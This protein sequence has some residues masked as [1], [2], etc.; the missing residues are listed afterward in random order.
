MAKTSHLIAF[1]LFFLLANPVLSQTNDQT[2]KKIDSLFARY[3]SQTP[4]VAVAIIKNG[5]VIFKKGYGMANLEND[6]PITPQ[7]VFHIASV[8]KQFTAFSIY[9]LA[10]QGK[11]SLEDD[12]R[13]YIPELPNYGTTIKIRHLLAHTS[14]LRDQWAILTL[15]GWRMDDVITTEQILKLVTNQ[16]STN[17]KPGSAFS[18]S[19][20]GYTLL[21][22]IVHRITGKTFSAYTSEQIFKPLGMTNT[23]F[24]DDH[25]RII[26]NRADSY[27][28]ISNTYYNKR[29]NFATVGATGLQTTVEDLSKWALN[30]EKPVVGDSKLI[31]A[32]N[33]PSYLDNG[34]KIVFTIIDG[35]TL[36]HAKAQ[37]LRNY[38]G[39]NIIKHGGHDAGFRAFLGRFPDQ[40]FSIITLSNDEHYEAFKTG[41]E[42]AEF[43]LKNDLHEKK[44]NNVIPENTSANPTVNYSPNLKEFEG[45]YHNDEL[46]TNY[47]FKTLGNKLIMYHSRL[48]DTALNPIGD[49]KFSGSGEQVF[50]FEMEFLRNEK[51]EVIGFVIS[52]FGAK[53]IK[54]VKV[55]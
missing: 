15:A 35:D 50:P 40:H 37:L 26:K 43:Y 44:K 17:F 54:F 8:S 13:K 51:K 21:A 1:V 52:N 30:F 27:E 38:R 6:I 49:S 5:E 7:T 31:E 24:Y 32:F 47:S 42:I 3:N 20:T 19:N 12:V 53:N 45:A 4:G 10:S 39:V 36:F 23:Q 2:G 18:Y 48:S 46:A 14:G 34:K 9:L 33:Q 16:K 11:I 28:M 55:T 41:L 22:E 25:R 29:L